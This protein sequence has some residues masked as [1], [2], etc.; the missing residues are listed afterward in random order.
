MAD[1]VRISINDQQ[2]VA[3]APPSSPSS[4][5]SQG[6]A[7]S[8]SS[9]SSDQL[10]ASVEQRLHL[11]ESNIGMIV[12]YI[13]QQEAAK[14]NAL[15]ASS[16]VNH[17]AYSI[18]KDDSSST[19][20]QRGVRFQSDVGVNRDHTPHPVIAKIMSGSADYPGPTMNE[21]YNGNQSSYQ[22]PSAGQQMS[23]SVGQQV[24]MQ[25]K[26]AMPSFPAVG[27][28]RAD[29]DDDS[30]S[31]SS[32]SSRMSH[33][34]KVL[35]AMKLDMP[36]KYKGSMSHDSAN[37]RIWVSQ[38]NN[39]FNAKKLSH[40]SNSALVLAVTRLDGYASSWYEN[41]RNEESINS[42]SD[43]RTMMF[44]RFEREDIE[45]V[46]AFAL[47]DTK[48]RT[49]ITT[50]THEFNQHVQMLP[51]H[52]RKDQKTLILMY[53]HG[54]RVQGTGL[55]VVTLK[56]Q[57]ASQELSTLNQVQNEAL[58]IESVLRSGRTGGNPSAA[59]GTYV[60][61]RSAGS[62]P[63]SSRFSRVTP[64]R[65]PAFSTPQKLNHVSAGTDQLYGGDS[66]LDDMNAL[67][68]GD[69]SD[70]GEDNSSDEPAKLPSF[71]EDDESK[72][73]MPSGGG[74]T[75]DEVEQVM[76]HAM[77]AQAKFGERLKISPEEILRCRKLNLCFKCKRP[78]HMASACPTT[79]GQSKNL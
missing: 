40:D 48:Y 3:S 37:L 74:A 12:Q 30:R 76:L 79:N 31:V 22:T 65:R 51:Q 4:F 21:S 75:A 69:G 63:S 57:I 2:S 43:L 20:F 52:L 15:S 34:D 26:P 29:E 7:V 54:L 46:S 78:G 64:P 36:S 28:G 62:S 61:T 41:I 67:I 50:Y 47:M 38:M 71:H 53:M 49:N 44:Q 16:S 45:E 18:V 58:K 24:P 73:S 19:P 39:W 9:S 17:S 23:D 66:S 8:S 1:Q 27:A 35:L 25:V 77:R 42:W 11:L 72:S 60:S 14:A 6:H 55:L 5:Q 56:N 68:E 33:E 59:A 13:Q 32:V 70:D 10:A